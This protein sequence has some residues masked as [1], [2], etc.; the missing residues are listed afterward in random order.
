MSSDHDHPR[1]GGLAPLA[2]AIVFALSAGG[3]LGVALGAVLDDFPRG[4]TY[5]FAFGAIAGAAIYAFVL[6]DRHG[7][8]S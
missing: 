6:R 5:G 7:P 2:I 4:L 8:R 1:G 3:G